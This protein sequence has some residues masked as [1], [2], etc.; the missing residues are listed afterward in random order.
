P[1]TP[2]LTPASSLLVREHLHPAIQ[3]LFLEAAQNI[4]SGPGIL[5][6]PGE[7]PEDEPVD[8]PLSEEARTYYKSGG[9]FLQRPLPFWLW[10]FATRLLLV[11]VP[12]AGVVYAL[13]RVI[14]AG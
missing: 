7:F 3:F 14:S 12:L 13:A 1:H 9:T 2:L 4:H 10:V 8:V 5:R 6:R 11:I